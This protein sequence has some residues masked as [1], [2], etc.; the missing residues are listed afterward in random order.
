MSNSIRSQLEDMK[1]KYNFVKILYINKNK[2]Y[3]TL[4]YNFN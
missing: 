4:K 2:W 3:I 1:I